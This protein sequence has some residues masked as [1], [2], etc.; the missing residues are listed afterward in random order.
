M[1]TEPKWIEYPKNKPEE[2]GDFGV[3]NRKKY[4]YVKSDSPF[5]REELVKCWHKD[6]SWLTDHYGTCVNDVTHFS[7]CARNAKA[8]IY[9]KER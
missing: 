4:Y 9:I 6:D 7:K 2:S 1:N 3:K 8:F 5:F